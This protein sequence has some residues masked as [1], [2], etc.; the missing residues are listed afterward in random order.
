[1][2]LLLTSFISI[3]SKQ[4]CIF[5]AFLPDIIYLM[6]FINN[7]AILHNISFNDFQL[8]RLAAIQKICDA[9][10]GFWPFVMH[11]NA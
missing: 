8:S 11:F 9:N 10:Q 1:M 2:Y 6:T 3:F 4:K 7:F 5:D